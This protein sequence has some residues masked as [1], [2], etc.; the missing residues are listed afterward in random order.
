MGAPFVDE[1]PD[2]ERGL[3]WDDPVAEDAE[4]VLARQSE[5]FSGDVP[6]WQ[7]H[8]PLHEPGGELWFAARPA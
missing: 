6:V 7:A 1:H 4:L 8:K 5:V 2:R 3:L